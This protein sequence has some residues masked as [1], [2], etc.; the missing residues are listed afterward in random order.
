MRR[1]SQK[2]PNDERDAEGHRLGFRFILFVRQPMS[3]EAYLRWGKK[4]R[5][6]I[7]KSKWVWRP[8]ASTRSMGMPGGAPPEM[9]KDD[10]TMGNYLLSRFFL[11]D[12]ETYGL[13]SWVQGRTKT[14]VKLTRTL[15]LIQVHNSEKGSFTISRSGRL[16][17]YWFR[18]TTSKKEVV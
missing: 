8:Y 3:A 6:A 12:G 4:S 13:R 10:N 5:V 9:F 17:R 16:S 2:N 14:H 7:S 11:S 1:F 18:K 15:A